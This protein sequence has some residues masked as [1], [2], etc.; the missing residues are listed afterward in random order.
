MIGRT[1]VRDTTSTKGILRPR[2]AADHIDLRRYPPGAEAGRFVER[3]WA[4]HWDLRGGDPYPVRLLS[5]PCVNIT[6]IESTGGVVHGVGTGTSRHPLSGAGRVFGVKFRPGGFF[7]LTGKPA[8][9]LTDRSAPLSEI[10]DDDG[11]A[12]EVLAAEDDPACRL[13]DEFIRERIPTRVDAGYDLL[14]RMIA[15]MLA[16]RTITRVDHLSERSGQSARTLQRIFQSY[17]GV[18]PKW[19][20]RRYRLHDGAERL[21]TDPGIDPAA[22]AVEL[23]W[24]DQAHFT[25]DFTAL[26]GTSPMAYAAACAES[27]EHE[28]IAVGG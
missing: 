4:V 17:V 19:L 25:R 23:G 28:P 27:G 20:I 8:R 18:G 2:Q 9:A 15:E 26:I 11:I 16:D 12:A 5:Q 24:F 1:N 7:A 6:F 3:Y 22:L 14:L 13:L 21:A 10:F